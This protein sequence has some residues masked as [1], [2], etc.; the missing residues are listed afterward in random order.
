EEFRGRYFCSSCSSSLPDTLRTHAPLIRLRGVWPPASLSAG[1]YSLS[2][3][4][5]EQWASQLHDS[6]STTFRIVGWLDEPNP[7]LP[8]LPEVTDF[9][10]SKS[11]GFRNVCRKRR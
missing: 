3:A 9:Q 1:S 11:I 2:F 5:S 10:E 7:P 8:G 6:T 4:S